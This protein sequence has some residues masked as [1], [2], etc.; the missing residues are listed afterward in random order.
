MNSAD[1]KFHWEIEA[2]RIVDE[3]AQF[4]ILPSSTDETMS[5]NVGL[6]SRDRKTK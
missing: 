4:A 6:H 2:I 1:V 5:T 3:S